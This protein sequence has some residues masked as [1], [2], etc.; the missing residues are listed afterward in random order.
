MATINVT[1]T[2]KARI[3]VLGDTNTV[4]AKGSI[5]KGSV[6]KTISGK[7]LV[8]LI[9]DITAKAW[10]RVY[11]CTK[12]LTAKARIT[13]MKFI[14]AKASVKQ[15]QQVELTAYARIFPTNV[16]LEEINKA[17][18]YTMGILEVMWDGIN[19]TDETKYFISA[20]GNIKIS[21][22]Y[23]E[24]IA[25]EADFELDNTD[26]RFLPENDEG[27]LYAY[28]E[29]RKRIKFSIGMG[30]AEASKQRIF[31]GYIKAIEP[32]RS[33]GMVNFHCFDDTIRL[34]NKRC[35]RTSML[36]QRVDQII[37]L[38]A[39]EAGLGSTEYYLDI[40]S[41]LVRAVALSDEYIWPTMG[42]LAAAER[43]RIFMDEYG[44]L[45]FWGRERM[46]TMKP[47]FTLSQGWWIK[48]LGF[49]VEE[50]AIKNRC[51]VTAT[52]RGSSGLQVVWT[53][54]DVEAMN[55][56]SDTLVW[57][58]AHS[59][60]TAWIEV[61]DPCSTWIQPIPVTDYIANSADDGTGSD[62]TE[63]VTVTRFTEYGNAAS[64]DVQNTADVPVY[65]T[66]FQIR[67][68]PIRIYRW[69]RVDY[70]DELSITKY[71]EQAIEIENEFID[72]EI[73]AR[74]MAECEVK[75][76]RNAKN[77]FK[78]KIIGIPHLRC[79][80]IVNLEVKKDLFEEY[81]VDEL[82]WDFDDNNG[83]SQQLSFVNKIVLPF[84]KYIEAFAHIRV[85]GTTKTVTA[86]AK[87]LK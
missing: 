59:A 29:P 65:L 56:Y 79:G 74:D 34:Q 24:G 83:Y 43:G 73:L 44:R 55:Q 38:L 46:N 33:T 9:K 82:D 20:K 71:G 25:G 48:E 28:L 70:K 47:T 45:R 18:R 37:E 69:I 13:G 52:P 40:S 17:V 85:Y 72:D 58:P 87:I 5:R 80:D 6:T 64:I 57:I 77:L 4:T 66:K 16:A 11:G 39:D 81:M 63:Y 86:M 27:E 10:I 3:K 23:G 2:S 35:P 67:A 31:T 32:N 41:H 30:T 15:H 78:A 21:G 7:A 12:T 14:W 49:S 84:T 51:V 53:N 36:D 75:R 68:N 42:K 1:I 54:G 19:W 50:Q 26:G 61:E 62:L 60:Q 8:L 22:D 76:W